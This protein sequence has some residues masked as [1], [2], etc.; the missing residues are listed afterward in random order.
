MNYQEDQYIRPR[1]HIMGNAKQ[2]CKQATPYPIARRAVEKNR[3]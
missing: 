2:E 3:P 1:T